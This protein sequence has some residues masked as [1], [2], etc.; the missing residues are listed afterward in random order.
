M[1]AL[2]KINN[3]DKLL[4]VQIVSIIDFVKTIDYEA[5]VKLQKEG[6]DFSNTYGAIGIFNGIIYNDAVAIQSVC[7][8]RME[9]LVSLVRIVQNSEPTISKYSKEQLK[10]ILS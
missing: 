7:N 8:Q 5:L 6:I 4:N 9:A 3:M 2:F 10:T 1:Q